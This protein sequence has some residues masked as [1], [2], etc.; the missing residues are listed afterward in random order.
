MT[1]QT[2]PSVP[3]THVTENGVL[4][5]CYHKCRAGVVSLL[6]P[7]LWLMWTVAFPLEHYIWTKTPLKAFAHYFGM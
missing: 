7:R 5:K 4:V 6:S 2:C 3:H 1:D